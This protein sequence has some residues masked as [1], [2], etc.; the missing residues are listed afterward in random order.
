M[1]D[2]KSTNENIKKENITQQNPHKIN[3]MQCNFS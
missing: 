2:K 1:K 3:L